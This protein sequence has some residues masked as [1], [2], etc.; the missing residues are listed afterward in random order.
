MKR[1][2]WPK[3]RTWDLT[4]DFWLAKQW[5]RS[6]LWRSVSISLCLRLHWHHNTLLSLCPHS[7]TFSEVQ[8]NSDIYW[9]FQRYN[10]IVQYHSRPSLAPPFIILSHINLFIKRVIRK[11]PSIKIHHFGQYEKS[12]QWVLINVISRCPRV[13]LYQCHVLFSVSLFYNR[14]SSVPLISASNRS[15]IIVYFHISFYSAVLVPA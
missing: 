12:L 9:K 6:H 8:A 3:F 11:V 14:L 4:K 5:P 2:L 13:G 7:S 10:L 15:L 1:A